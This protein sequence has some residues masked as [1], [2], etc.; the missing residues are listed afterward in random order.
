MS[1]AGRILS[2]L[3]VPAL[4]LALW[5]ALSQSGAFRPEIL[6]P[7]WA[8]VTRWAAYLA[9][10]EA[11]APGYDWL[12]WLNSSEM[13][14]DATSS[15]YRVL[16]GFAIGGGLAL[17]LGLLMGADKRVY[18]LFDPLVQFLRPIPPIA[19]IPLSIL[20][21]GLGNPPALFLISIGAFFPVL[22][23]T[24]AGVRQVDA[25]YIRAARNLGAGAFTLFRRVILPAAM[26]YILAGARIGL[27]TAFIVV[28]VAEMIAVNSG[29]GYRILEAREYL[30]SD[31]VMAGMITIGMIGLALD[32]LMTRLSNYLLRWHR[33]LES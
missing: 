33:G 14:S 5:Q 15:L 31:K 8:V 6:P 17:P 10:Q 4:V 3:I 12:A 9:P 28:I 25:I 24:I 16:A 19:Y 13:L 30:W 32:L 21:F 1:R 7:P 11:L 22:L 29:L 2:G 23:N 20:W 27:G 26:P 18:A